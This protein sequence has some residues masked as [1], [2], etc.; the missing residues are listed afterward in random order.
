MTAQ[1]HK[2]LKAPV[3]CMIITISDTRTSTTDKSGQ[4]MAGLLE[5]A[6]H[7]V[8]AKKIIPDQKEVIQKEIEN[9]CKDLNIDAI[10]TNGG[11]G[12]AYRDVTIETV[13]PMLSK[14]MSGFGEIFRMLSYQ[15][16]IGS[17]AILSRAIA[18]VIDHTPIFATPGS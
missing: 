14:E 17:S 15:E 2:Q 1:K 9:G 11:T 8:E 18:G 5:E 3:N 6:G 16:D 13:K 12:I 10:L 7:R 4:L